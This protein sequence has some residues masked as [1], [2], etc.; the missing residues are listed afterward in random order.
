LIRGNAI[1]LKDSTRVVAIILLHC[2]ASRG[3]VLP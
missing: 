2:V 1:G 3:R